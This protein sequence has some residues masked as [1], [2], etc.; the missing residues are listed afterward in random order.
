MEIVR[1]PT[2]RWITI[3]AGF[4]FW[5]GYSIGFF[6][7]AYFGTVYPNDRTLYNILNAVVVSLG[8]FISSLT[9]AIIS[10]KGENGGNNMTKAY[11]CMIGTFLGIPTLA[12]CLLLQNSFAL[13]MAFLFLEYLTAECWTAPAISMLQA[14][15]PANARGVGISVYLL[16]ATVWGTVANLINGE[17][18]DALVTE[19]NP[20]TRGVILFLVAGS[21]YALSIP[22]FLLAGR[23]YSEFKRQAEEPPLLPSP[24]HQDN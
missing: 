13:S 3:A 11:V 1:S 20:G 22:F 8:G 19:D 9:G 5:A 15:L 4:R 2:S 12:G 21:A 7:P 16:Y 24:M 14:T 6:M 10:D 17:L 23:S 18:S